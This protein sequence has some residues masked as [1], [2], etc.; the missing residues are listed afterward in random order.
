MGADPE[1]GTLKRISHLSRRCTDLFIEL[2]KKILLHDAVLL[3]K[4]GGIF[5]VHIVIFSMSG[6]YF[7]TLLTTTL[8]F[9]KPRVLLPGLTSEI[10]SVTL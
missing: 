1:F 4:D 10:V 7:R 8:Y 5:S 6:A 3:L 9:K 2:R